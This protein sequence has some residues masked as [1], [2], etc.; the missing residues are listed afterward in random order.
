MRQCAHGMF[1]NLH[2]PTSLTQSRL[3]GVAKVLYFGYQTIMLDMEAE[4]TQLV[5]SQ[6]ELLG[7]CSCCDR[8]ESS[9][10]FRH[11][12]CLPVLGVHN[13]TFTLQWTQLMT[14]QNINVFGNLMVKYP[15]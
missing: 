11:V 1:T 12:I 4:L 6:T 7:D 15:D 5:S 14:A 2:Q 13:N 3:P 9:G 10:Y 8:L